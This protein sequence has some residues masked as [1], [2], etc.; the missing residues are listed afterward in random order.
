MKDRHVRKA[1]QYAQQVVAGEIPACKWVIAAC[2]R[3]LDDLAR[4][5]ED[6][7][8][9]FDEKAAGRVCRFIENLPHVKGPRAGS[10]IQLEP[11]QCFILTTVFGWL[12]R[13]T[14]KRRIRRVYL[15]EPRGNAKSTISSGVGLYMLSADGEGGAEVYSVATTKDQARITFADAQQM[16]RKRPDLCA[17]LGI[18]VAAHALIQERSTSRFAALAADSNTLDGLNVHLAIIDELHAH[19]TREVYDVMETACGKRDQTLMWTI[20]TAGT[21]RSGIAYE[22]R[23]YLT[24]IL[25][26]VFEDESF[27]GCIWTIDD[28][29]DWQTE[30]A[31]RKANPNWGVSVQPEI[32]AQLAAKAMQMPAAQSNFKTKHLCIWVNADSA[33]MDM[34]AWDRCADPSL[35]PEQFAGEA[36]C[37]ALDL[38]TKTDIAARIQ[39][40]RRDVQG[41][42]HYYAFGRYYLPESAA[43]DG[44]NA[45]YSGWAVSGR[46]V[47]TDGDVL[48]FETIRT[49]AL[50][51]ATEYD[52]RVIGYDP[53]QAT[54][55]AQQLTADGAA[56]LE[57]RNTVSNF[58]APMKEIDALVRAGRFHYDGD[59][60]LTWMVSNVVCHMDAKE[61]IY[62]RKERPENKIDGVVAL[63]MAMGLMTTEPPDEYATGRLIR[64]VNRQAQRSA[65][66]ALRRCLATMVTASEA[67]RRRLA[68]LHGEALALLESAAE[69]RRQRSTEL[70]ITCIAELE[71][72]M[73]GYEPATRA[74]AIQ[75]RLGLSR[76]RYYA[77]RK[78]ALSPTAKVGLPS[79]L[80]SPSES[81]AE[82]S[83]L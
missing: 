17:D 50:A 29:D 1:L 31:W 73:R 74:S 42:G 48:D 59:P 26:G 2:Q 62:P 23:T 37:V 35:K 7:A 13:A 77:L 72:Q 52:V 83:E 44:R 70:L 69:P 27:F 46:L 43:Q 40:F 33:W 38:A 32:V 4:W 71:R 51:L 55:L 80:M 3:Q 24:K 60:V 79:G 18:E 54:Q 64:A 34:R 45:Q 65:V 21:D 63:I 6:G 14:G 8:Y 9:R 81:G 36:C 47:V 56:C 15:E 41:V 75:S 5:R 49:E 25:G 53:W 66:A 11:W 58:S 28:G 22:I 82:Q 30:E 61:N 67:E 57:Y 12:V 20:T 10:D 68:S 78:L 76:T 16:A 19:P 39:L